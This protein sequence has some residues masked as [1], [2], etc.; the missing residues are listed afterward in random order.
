MEKTLEKYLNDPTNYPG[1]VRKVEM[2]QTHI[3][4]VFLA[5]NYV[6]K[7]KKPVDFGFLDFT[8]LAKRKFYCQQE[9]RLNQRLA[10]DIY[11]GIVPIGLAKGKY[12]WQGRGQIVEYAVR[13]KR[14]PADRMMD[15]LLAENKVK[16]KDIDNIAKILADF[17]AR[18]ATDPT[19][20]QYGS[21]ASIKG[22]C[23]ENS[24][25]TREF[26]GRVLSQDRFDYLD[27]YADQFLAKNKA[28]FLK[29]IKQGR[30]RECHGDC[31]SKN[32]CLAD[33]VYIYDCIEFNKRFSC[34]DVASEIAFLAMDLDFFGREDLSRR[35]V[36]KYVRLSG[37][38]DL[39]KLMDFYKCY[40]AYVRGKIHAFAS[41]Q[42][43]TDIE[44]EKQL[45]LSRKYFRQAYRYAGGRQRPRLII[46][47][48]L[49][50]S[51]KSHLAAKL[52]KK[53]D[54]PVVSSDIIRK[55][56]AGLWPGQKRLVGFGRDIYSPA[57]TRRTYQA[58]LDQARDRLAQGQ[59][60][61]LDATFQPRKYLRQAYEIAQEAGAELKVIECYCPEAELKK[62][63]LRRSQDKKAIS[64]GRWE[65]YLAQKKKYR[66]ITGIPG[67]Y[68]SRIK[69]AK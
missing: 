43:K 65:I 20:S 17:H 60:I 41:R 58:M 63:F 36:N 49:T 45:S 48:G 11:L 31:Y 4:W 2:V 16:V 68:L 14:L 57:F 52:A 10:P 33:K 26:I 32:I 46:I 44:R 40:R 39:P 22:N 25:Q 47:C 24:D 51:G 9:I 18:A 38:R 13:M 59:G 53:H 64:D 67:K 5:G 15:I 23:A 12:N 1:S 29:R 50:G 37:D 7:V 62:R 55:Q 69:T 19:I 42:V 6:Y 61:I 30:I 35:L 3:S 56:L 54:L 28:L 34:T 21:L 8:A 27:E 66:P